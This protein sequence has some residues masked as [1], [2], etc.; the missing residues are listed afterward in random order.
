MWLPEDKLLITG[1]MLVAPIPFAFDSP[2]VEWVRTLGRAAELGAE[3]IVPGHGA[4]QHDTRYLVQVTA[5]L[6]ATIA[7]VQDARAAG[8]QYEDLPKAVD[9]GEHER[10]FTGDDAVRTYAWRSYYYE[11]GLRSAWTSL[12]YPVPDD[13]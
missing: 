12:G 8:V 11:P 10:R 3:V 13:R 9:L 1:D 6:E 4:V 5:L 2:M 7:A